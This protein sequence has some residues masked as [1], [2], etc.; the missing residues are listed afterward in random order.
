M[1]LRT[2]SRHLS[3]ERRHIAK[4]PTKWVKENLE[5]REISEKSHTVKLGRF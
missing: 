3:V 1:Q 4:Q 2:F 5:L